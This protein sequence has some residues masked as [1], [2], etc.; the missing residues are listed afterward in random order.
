MAGIEKQLEKIK[1]QLALLA[2]VMGAASPKQEAEAKRVINSNKA[3]AE[4]EN[5]KEGEGK[6]IKEMKKQ[7]EERRN[8]K[9]EAL[10][11]AKKLVAQ[12]QLVKNS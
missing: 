1:K 9:E 11:K 3:R 4:E 2:A 6:K 8:K 7:V 10:E 5:R 12:A